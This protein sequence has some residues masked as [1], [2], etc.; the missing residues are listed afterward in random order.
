VFR[1]S[2][3]HAADLAYHLVTIDL[4]SKIDRFGGGELSWWA[5]G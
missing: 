4:I 2:L 5:D 3:G 1:R